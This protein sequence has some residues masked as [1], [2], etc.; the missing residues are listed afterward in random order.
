MDLIAPFLQSPRYL[1]LKGGING[2]TALVR[3]VVRHEPGLG[4]SQKGFQYSDTFRC[5]AV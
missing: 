3:N 2:E 1:L 4:I 5:G